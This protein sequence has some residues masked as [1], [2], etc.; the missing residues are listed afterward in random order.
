MPLIPQQHTLFPHTET[1]KSLVLVNGHIKI[2]NMIFVSQLQPME[3]HKAFWNPVNPSR[4]LKML[5]HNQANHSPKNAEGTPVS[6]AWH[7]ASLS[8]ES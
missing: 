8:R 3:E 7:E 6:F 2:Q 4:L 1:P 5:L